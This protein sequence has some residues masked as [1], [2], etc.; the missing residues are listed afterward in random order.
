MAINLL[1]FSVRI[2]CQLY[3]TACSD[4]WLTNGFEREKPVGLW[5]E[6]SCGLPL[7]NRNKEFYGVTETA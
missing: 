4:Q 6:L 1:E 2:E 7:K 5:E 3:K